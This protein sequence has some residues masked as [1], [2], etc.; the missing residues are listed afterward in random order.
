MQSKLDLCSAR[1]P[2]PEAFSALQAGSI[3]VEIMPRL[4]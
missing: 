4:A 3:A 1:G 2:A